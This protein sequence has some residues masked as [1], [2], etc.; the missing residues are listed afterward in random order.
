MLDSVSLSIDR[1]GT[2]DHRAECRP[3]FDRVAKVVFR[4]KE[5][6]K[7]TLTRPHTKTFELQ[8]TAALARPNRVLD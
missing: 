7:R 1:Y 4:E 5:R 2:A 6:K 3:Y 8:N